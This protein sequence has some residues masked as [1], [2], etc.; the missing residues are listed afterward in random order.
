MTSM[1]FVLSTFKVSLRVVFQFDL[2]VVQCAV[3]SA[4]VPAIVF[5][6]VP[7][8]FGHMSVCEVDSCPW[9]ELIVRMCVE[10]V[11]ADEGCECK[12]HNE[13][14]AQLMLRPQRA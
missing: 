4:V 12:L 9:S 2:D 5:L 3:P 6:A 7:V 14:E 10:G 8:M 1:D 13:E 11:G